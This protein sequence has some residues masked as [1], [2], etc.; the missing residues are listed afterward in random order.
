MSNF[1]IIDDLP[2]F[3]LLTELNNLIKN[4]IIFWSKDNQICLN[5]TESQLDN[6]LLGS[7]SLEYDWDNAKEIV[8]EYGNSSFYVPKYEVKY[9]EEDFS[10]LCT[11][12]KGT[13]FEE[14]CNELS[15]R[16]SLGRVRLM[17]SK[18]KTCL[19]WHR[20]SSLRIHYPIKTQEGCFMVINNEV[21]HLEQN[22]W[23]WINTTLPHTAFNASKEDRIHLVAVVLEKNNV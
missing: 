6:F 7:G 20:D 15:K 2:S 22:T 8:D 21:M 23:W 12:F 3:D 13:L 9:K 4:D 14:V 5:T 11:Q 1:K 18:P 10:V 17:K 19:S 16:Y